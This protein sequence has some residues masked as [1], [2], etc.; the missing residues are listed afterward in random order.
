[1][2]IVAYWSLLQ[3][4]KEHEESGLTLRVASGLV[5]GMQESW[6]Y[7]IQLQENGRNGEFQ[8]TIRCLMLYMLTR[9]I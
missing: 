8:E 4:T 7:I 3:P 2:E 9:K 6:P 1:M 5:N